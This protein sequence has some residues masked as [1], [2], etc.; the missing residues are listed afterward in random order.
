MHAQYTVRIWDTAAREYR[1]VVVTVEVDA[2]G[3]AEQYAAKAFANKS[4]VVK[5]C[6]GAVK[7]SA[8]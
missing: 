1:N 8:K 7:V 4:R 6:H 3:L 2:Y 5:Q